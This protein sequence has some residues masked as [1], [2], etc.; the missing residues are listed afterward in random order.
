MNNDKNL[1]S[2]NRLKVIVSCAV[3]ALALL[4]CS[5]TIAYGQSGG[6]RKQIDA[7]FGWRFSLGDPA[8]AQDPN[9]DDSSWRTINV[10]HDWSIEGVPDPKNLSGS[11][12]GYFPTGVGWYR[13]TFRVPRTWESKRVSVEFDGVYMDSTVYLNG[14]ALGTHP[15][16]YTSFAF[17]LS[18]YLVLGRTNVLAVRV[19][20][21]KQPNSRWYTGSGIYRHVRIVVTNPVHIAHWGVFVTTPIVTAA[22]A[23][24]V[25]HIRVANEAT[26]ATDVA[27]ETSIIS[28][29]GITVA[30]ARSLNPLA[31][32][33]NTAIDQTISL[34]NPDLWSPQTPHLYRAVTRVIQRGK[35]VDEVATMF[36]IRSLAWSAN[37][38]LMLNG[39]PIKL[40]GGSVH[41]DNGPLGAAAFDRA[42][43]RKV[44]L[45]KAAGDNAVR[46]AHNPPSPAF[47]DA[48]DRLGILVLED[49]FDVWET[50]KVKYDYARFFDDW[51]KRDLDSM[52]LRDRNHPSVIMWAI[53]NEIPEAW[54][55]A[56]APIAKKL[57]DEIR[58]LDS[59]RP[60]TEAFPGA[61]YTANTDAVFAKVDIGGYNYNL[62]ANQAKD[63][64]RVPSR[65]MLTTESFPSDAFE[66]WQLAR[67]KSY[68]LGDFVWTSMDYLG[69]SGIG[70]WGEG[71]PKQASQAEQMGRFMKVFTTKMGE[72]GQGPFNGKAPPASPMF[73]GYPWFG[74]YCGD[75]DI[76]GFRKPQSHY[77][78]ILWNGGDRV[79]AAV[80][81]PEPDGKKI[82]AIGWA[83]YPSIASWTWPSQEGKDLQVEVYSRTDQVRL[84]L[85]GKIIG[86][87]PTGLEQ[88]FRAVFTVPYI[89]GTL[90]VEGVR[91][92]QVVAETTLTTA[93]AATALRLTPDRSR[94]AADGEDLSFV[95]IEAVD[96]TGH[97]QPNADNE[98]QLAITGPGV[99]AALGTGDTKNP[100]PYQSDHRRLFNGRALVVIRST[101]RRG[102][103]TLNV[104]GLGMGE[105][106]V[107]IIAKTGN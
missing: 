95:T 74:S 56:G 43:E 83:V 80:R 72:N 33:Q 7:D 2:I 73:P 64:A 17:D 10:P 57:S 50:P 107:K 97:Y 47:L 94:I 79:Y 45:L 4:L 30:T 54:T 86:E 11:G 62:A 105:A 20:N 35:V 82:F 19:D 84:Y 78:D 68:I 103:I 25:L 3:Q 48:C 51:W 93:G 75:L 96:S 41:A 42:E 58:S 70:A 9:F 102:E 39:K 89:P 101:G 6:P 15:N 22:H 5:Y 23:E 8:G 69:E 77:R 91:N 46:T 67:N 28:R 71:T 88:Q 61:T 32:G 52:V 99:I 63:H 65:I 31:N 12:G 76:T 13:K 92:G 60:I 49:S 55:P 21:S 66:Q 38:G 16:G 24:V 37:G 59:T 36:G 27:V 1:C 14:H 34:P 100:E 98:V 44:E 26:T 53:G 85:N 81:L 29:S 90:K 40:H 106:R 18:P 104:K 87:A